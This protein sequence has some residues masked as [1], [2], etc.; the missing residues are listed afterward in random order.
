LTIADHAEARQAGSSEAGQDCG[1]RMA[2]VAIK[3][4]RRRVPYRDFYRAL[5]AALLLIFVFAASFYDGTLWPTFRSAQDRS[6]TGD[7]FDHALRTGS[8][9]IVPPSGNHCKQRL[10]DNVTWI[11]RDNGFV[12]CDELVTRSIAQPA[13]ETSSRLDAIRDGFRK[14]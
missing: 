2:S 14:K 13:R 4:R 11:I 3:Q 8:L 7:P 12:D 1:D 6:Y 9:L 10:I 5:L